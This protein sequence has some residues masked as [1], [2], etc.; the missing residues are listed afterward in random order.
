MHI[1]KDGKP[2]S[3]G[4]SNFPITLA[5]LMRLN[6]QKRRYFRYFLFLFYGRTVWQA[7]GIL[8]TRPGIVMPSALQAWSL[9]HG[10]PG[11]SLEICFFFYDSRHQSQ[12]DKTK[13]FTHDVSPSAT[14]LCYGLTVSQHQLLS[15]VRLFVTPWT[16]ARQAPLSMEF[17]RQE[18]WS[19]LPFPSPGDLPH[20]GIEPTSPALAGGFFFFFKF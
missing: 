3:D 12:R 18:Y 7:C 5:S 16:A 6:K 11:Q 19:G 2:H 10:L 1:V 13:F 14:L 4:T 9:N 15:R 8:V 20:K 17:S